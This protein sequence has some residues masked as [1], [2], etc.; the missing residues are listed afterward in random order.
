MTRSRPRWANTD[1]LLALLI[2]GLVVVALLVPGWMSGSPSSVSGNGVPTPG[3][4]GSPAS[5]SSSPAARPEPTGAA[6]TAPTSRT[7]V[8]GVAS[9]APPS[10]PVASGTGPCIEVPGPRIT[11]VSFNMHSALDRTRNR[12]ELDRIAQELRGYNADVYLL[13]EVDRNRRWSG[14]TDQPAYLADRLGF[15]YAF[16]TN[17][18]RWGNS[19]YGTAILSRYPVADVR[20]TLLP[21]PGSTQQR[22]LLHL[23]I[24]PFGAPISL[25]VTH[26][27]NTS[28][29]ARSAQARS[30][31]QV[32]AADPLPKVLGGDLNASPA[33][34]VLGTLRG[35]LADSWSAAGSGSGWTHPSWAPRMRIDY[36]LYGGGMKPVTAQVVP[37]AVSDHAA[38]RTVFELPSGSPVCLP[39]V[40]NGG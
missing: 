35:Q 10:L 6:P 31:A 36:L 25:Y 4:G 19:Q 11:V 17:V 8:G 16:G 21:R 12:V 14:R 29:A 13:Q 33:S 27:E 24:T 3:Q 22:G 23:R 30:I 15:A 26:L 1:V 40:G 18:Q 28:A 20:N 38:V 32:V 9:P 39:V 34:T 5:G 7:R 37:S 2:V